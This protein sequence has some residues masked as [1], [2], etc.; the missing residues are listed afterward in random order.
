M[1]FLSL[2]DMTTDICYIASRP[3][4]NS[5][6]WKLSIFS[7]VL[8]I[9]GPAIILIFGYIFN[10]LIHVCVFKVQKFSLHEFLTEVANLCKLS[11]SFVFKSILE[12]DILK[13]KAI[14]RTAFL[15]HITIE[16]FPQLV[17]Q[18]VTNQK[19]QLWHEPFGIISISTSV[20]MILFTLLIVIKTD[21]YYL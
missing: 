3:M 11:H 19:L 15:I 21:K 8:N 10:T 5:F 13:K 6:L 12:Q 18:S 17:I 4:V 14:Y 7:I 1:S 20:L 2:W 9:L 16:S